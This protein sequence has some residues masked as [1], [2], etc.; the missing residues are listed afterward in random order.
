MKQKESVLWELRGS[1]LHYPSYLFG[2]MH[3]RDEKAYT[4]AQWARPYL[5]SC[6]AFAA[7]FDLRDA[8][9]AAF[10]ARM[11]LPEG[12]R[13]SQLLSPGTY[14]RLAQIV[15]RE[16]GLPIQHFEYRHPMAL[17]NALVEVQFAKTHRQPLDQQLYR[18]A[19]MQGK[20]VTGVETW[21]EQMQV[22]D[23]LSL[24][25]QLSSLRV[26]A[27]HFKRFRKQ[28]LR[29]AQYYAEGRLQQLYKSVRRSSGKSRHSLIYQRNERMAERIVGLMQL[30]TCFMAVGAAHLPGS[31]GVLRLL[32]KRGLQLRPVPVPQ[33]QR[34]A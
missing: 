29:S 20:I 24:K 18:W 10:E 2:T 14:R 6:T 11:Q 30:H 31:K 15:E 26:A 5:E 13:L 16:L 3:L 28:A 23:E 22:F 34:P 12:Q 8:D 17:S 1:G 4:Y 25:D 21:Q 32:K 9:P 7:E 27:T 19:L 33:Q